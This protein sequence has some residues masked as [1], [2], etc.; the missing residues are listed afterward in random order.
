MKK[1]YIMLTQNSS[2]SFDETYLIHELFK[3]LKTIQN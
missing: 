2:I 3:Y 1:K